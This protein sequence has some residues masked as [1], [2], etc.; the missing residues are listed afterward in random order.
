MSQDRVPLFAKAL[1]GL[2]AA[3]SAARASA[4]VQASQASPE[5]NPDDEWR[6]HK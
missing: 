5:L 6:Y 4:E 2:L 3:E 1:N